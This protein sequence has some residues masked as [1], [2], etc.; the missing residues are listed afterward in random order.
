MFFSRYKDTSG[1]LS[2][3]EIGVKDLEEEDQLILE[4][5]QMVFNKPVPE[6]IFRLETPRN[7][8]VVSQ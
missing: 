5:R 2:A 1:I 6:Q 4:I 7:F 8:E 3:R